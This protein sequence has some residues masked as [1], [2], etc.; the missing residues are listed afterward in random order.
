V[1]VIRLS[2]VAFALLVAALAADRDL[3]GKHAGEWKSSGSGNGGDIKFT[4]EPGAN[5]EWKCELTFGLGGESV[6]TTMRSAKVQ[7]S[8]IDLT[9][10]FDALGA[11]LRSHVT[12]EWK[13]D[14]FRGEYQTTSVGDGSPVDAGTWTAS[15][16]K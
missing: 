13:G 15:R 1:A 10:D 11:T 4:L 2:L 12:G 7:D 8:K 16:A 14:G 6:K 3:A 5:G 9:Y